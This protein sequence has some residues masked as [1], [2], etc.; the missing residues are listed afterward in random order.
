MK[1]TLFILFLISSTDLTAQNDGWNISTNNNTDYTGIA[2]A[3]GRIGMLTS[4][5]PLE[6]SH[7]QFT[8]TVAKLGRSVT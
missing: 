8:G 1:N 7:S 5:K 6:T 4:A 2:I 3:N